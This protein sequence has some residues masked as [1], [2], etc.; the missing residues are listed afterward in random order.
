VGVVE[1]PER[2]SSLAF[3]GDH[4]HTL[5]IGARSSVYAIEIASEGKQ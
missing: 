5:F 4:L 2:P 1:I 3:G